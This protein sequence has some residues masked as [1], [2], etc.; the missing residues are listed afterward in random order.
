MGSWAGGGGGRRR[1]AH[2]L[3]EAFSVQVQFL[4]KVV[5]VPAV[6][7]VQSIYKVVDVPAAQVSRF[8]GAGGRDRRLPQL[9]S[10]RT[11]RSPT[12]R[13]WTRLLASPSLCSRSPPTGWSISLP[14]RSCSFQQLPS[15]EKT[16]EIP[17]LQ[18]SEDGRCPCCGRSCV[19]PWFRL[20]S[21]RVSHSCVV[22]NLVEVPEI[23]AFVETV[24][25]TAEASGLRGLRPR[26]RR[27]MC[28]VRVGRLCQGH[29]SR[30]ACWLRQGC[31]VVL[32]FFG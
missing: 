7:G 16:V 13:S 8:S 12:S 27:S 11:R 20:W 21:I 29:V 18:Y 22:E 24:Q 5:D 14:C 28:Q 25:K 26:G 32:I 3:A 19:V 6:L 2:F 15:V 31:G 30:S 23:R 4:D 1:S 9:R 17:Q 10:L